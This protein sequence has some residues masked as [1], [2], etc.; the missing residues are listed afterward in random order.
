MDCSPTSLSCHTTSV[1]VPRSGSMWRRVSALSMTAAATPPA[2]NWVVVA[3][4]CGGDPFLNRV[5]QC[6]TGAPDERFVERVRY[7]A[8]CVA[9]EFTG[10]VYHYGSADQQAEARGWVQRIFLEHLSA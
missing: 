9:V 4:S 3:W 6:Y 2:S 8:C 1:M 10:D 7:R 5:L